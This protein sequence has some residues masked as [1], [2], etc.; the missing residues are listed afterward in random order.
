MGVA[1]GRGAGAG[2]PGYGAFLEALRDLLVRSDMMPAQR[3][4]ALRARLVELLT[5]APGVVDPLVAFLLGEIQPS[6]ESGLS[7]DALFAA[8]VDVLR[9]LAA[10][11]PIVLVVE[12][13]QLAGPGTVE[14]FEQVARCVPG[15]A[16]FLVGVYAT[17]E[18]EEDSVLEAATERLRQEDSVTSLHLENLPAADVAVED[19]KMFLALGHPTLDGGDDK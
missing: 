1:A 5:E 12:D 19:G 13:L 9:A 17:D 6:P 11:R 7:R 16:I 14:L 2:G 15:H 10:E 18:M 8:T 3:C 4:L